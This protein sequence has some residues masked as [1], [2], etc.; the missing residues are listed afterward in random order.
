MSLA[1][2]CRA[3]AADADG[4]LTSDVELR[5]EGVSDNEGGGAEG[6]GVEE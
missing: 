4:T 6:S 5:A 2:G 3:R 1:G